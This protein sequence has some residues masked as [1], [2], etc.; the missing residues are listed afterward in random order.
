VAIAPEQAA[1]LARSQAGLASE[2]AQVWAV[3]RLS[4]REE[5][6]YLVVLGAEDHATG[7][8]AVRAS[9]GTV[10]SWAT[11]D[12]SRPHLGI[13]SAA[14]IRLAELGPGARAELVWVPSALS[15][16][17]LYPFWSVTDGERTRY[18]DLQGGGW[19]AIEPGGRGG[20]P[21]QGGHK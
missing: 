17:P 15:Q 2:A 5:D 20:A 21:T 13:D 1:H 14:A 7:L 9:D 6:Y 12:G 18:V 8:A 11:L 19:D 3:R 4:S 10:L 16:S